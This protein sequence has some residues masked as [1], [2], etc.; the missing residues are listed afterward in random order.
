VGFS[1]LS[2]SLPLLPFL[3]QLSTPSYS[4]YLYIVLNILN[5]SFPWSSSNPRPHS[6]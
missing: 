2:N 5:P 1:L 4:H 3:T 6:A